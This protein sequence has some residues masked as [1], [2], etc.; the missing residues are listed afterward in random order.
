MLSKIKSVL[1]IAA[2]PG[3]PLLVGVSGGPD[4]VALLHALVTLGYRP[5][6]CHYNHRWR[7]ADSDGDEEFVR[8]LA[9][10]LNLPATIGRARRK[11]S[12]CSEADARRAR[13]AFFERVAKQTGISTLVLAHTADDQA[14]TVLL[15]LI[16]GAG[17]EGL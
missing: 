7:G 9:R 1:A 13:F 2:P 3:T 15:R 6:V 12:R 5:H 8:N 11:P 10:Q 16:R 17:L 4:S 14:E